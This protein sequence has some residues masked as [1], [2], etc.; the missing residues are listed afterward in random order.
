[1]ENRHA[2]RGEALCEEPETSVN[3]ELPSPI[4][5]EFVEEVFSRVC[6][7]KLAN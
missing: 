2:M 1:M 3:D 6:I 4:N 5:D 7:R